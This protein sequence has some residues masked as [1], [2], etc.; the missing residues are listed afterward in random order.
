M[1]RRFA[2]VAGIMAAI[3]ITLLMFA[4]IE[5]AVG[6]PHVI[7]LARVGMH[8]LAVMLGSCYFMRRT[9]DRVA[10]EYQ[11]SHPPVDEM[12]IARAAA[13]LV[14][15]E[16]RA[17]IRSAVDQAYRSGMVAGAERATR[18]NGHSSG[19][20]PKLAHLPER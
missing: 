7:E 19:G 3:I 17:E 2:N 15:D 1:S 13:K 5:A 11:D 12:H 4:E 6:G 14:T 18:S 16:L 8:I 20:F 10:A 9:L